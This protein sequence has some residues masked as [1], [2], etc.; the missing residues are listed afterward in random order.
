MQVGAGDDPVGRAEALAQGGAER[1]DA[2]LGARRRAPDSD[3]GRL[4][5]DAAQGRPEAEIDEDAAGVR[6]ELQAG[7]GLVQRRA[8]LQHHRRAAAPGERERGRQ[9]ADAGADDRDRTRHRAGF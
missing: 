9:P 2:N 6:R 3:A 4:G 7:S 5:R 1:H 8:A